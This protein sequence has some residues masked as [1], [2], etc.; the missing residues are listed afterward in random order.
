MGLNL[1]VLTVQN[2]AIISNKT[3]NFNNIEKLLAPY[4]GK[5][6]DIINFA[7]VWATGWCCK[8]FQND[9]E[10]VENSPIIDFLKS[11]SE[12]FDALV[13]GGSFIRKTKNNEYKN[14]CP[15]VNRGKLAAI[16]DKM[17]LYSHKGSEE[18]KF[19][20]NGDNLLIVDTGNTKIGTSICYDIR[21]PE[22]YREYSKNGVEILIHASA[23]S[24]TKPDHWE[25]MH[26]ARAME[27]QCFMI[28]A[29]QCGKIDKNNCNLGHSLVADAWG[30]IENELGEEEACMHTIINIDKLRDLRKNFPLLNDRRDQNFKTFKIKEIKLYE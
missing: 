15:I 19:I 8:N 7:E 14:S 13:F 24:K 26:R 17:H 23:W 25:I 29:D 11:V 9:A 27:N 1:S 30:N 6:I 20:T 16:Y 3:A 22:I 5:Q 10:S 28:V 21:Y 12:E 18:D 4:Q 2:N